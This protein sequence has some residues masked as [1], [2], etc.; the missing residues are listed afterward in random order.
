MNL[1]IMELLR[2]NQVGHNYAIVNHDDR[3]VG[4]NPVSGPYEGYGS[5]FPPHMAY[6]ESDAVESEI[7][8]S[9]KSIKF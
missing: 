1:L 9:L 7:H 6:D 2:L 3:D 4:I 5:V 8:N